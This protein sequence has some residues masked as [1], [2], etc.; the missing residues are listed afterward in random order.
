MA[1]ETSTL[2]FSDLGGKTAGV[3]NLLDDIYLYGA[4]QSTTKLPN[5]AADTPLL[6]FPA[7]Q[8]LVHHLWQAVA[9]TVMLNSLY[10]HS[11]QTQSARATLPLAPDVFPQQVQVVLGH[12]VVL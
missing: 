5:C 3:Q 1:T 4:V 7:I 8:H 2:Q 9:E 11:G 12:S 6:H 10:F